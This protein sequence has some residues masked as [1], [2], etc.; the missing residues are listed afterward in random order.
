MCTLCMSSSDILKLISN[1]SDTD[2]KD[3]NDVV[4]VKV[5]LSIMIIC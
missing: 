1:A 2:S 3:R 5:N 4:K